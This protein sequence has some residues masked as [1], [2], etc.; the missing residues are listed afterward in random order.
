VKINQ[1]DDKVKCL[2]DLLIKLLA[3]RSWNRW[4]TELQWMDCK[5]G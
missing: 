3:C 1:Q 2:D 5:R 4:Q